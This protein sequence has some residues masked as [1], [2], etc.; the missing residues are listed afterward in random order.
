LVNENEMIVIIKWSNS[1]E[2]SNEIKLI[3][4]DI[5]NSNVMVI[6]M[7]IC[8]IM[9]IVIM[10]NNNNNEIVSECNGHNIVMKIV[11]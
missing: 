9:V 3:T 4:N 6:A 10:S 2:S 8:V 11:M 1:N 5:N 7:V